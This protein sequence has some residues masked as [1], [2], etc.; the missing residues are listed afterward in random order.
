MRILHLGKYYYPIPGG[1]ESFLK[2][3][4]EGLTEIGDS[5]TVLCSS[6]ALAGSTETIDGVSV[7]RSPSFG[8]LFS[9][10]LTPKLLFTLHRLAR[11]HDIVHVHTPN[12]LVEAFV[13]TLPSRVPVVVSHHSDVIRQRLLLP[14]YAP[15]L[16]R[17]LR[18]A[19][20]IAVATQSHV[21]HSAY[22]PEFAQ[23]C[24]VIPYGFDPGEL[25]RSAPIEREAA[26]LKGEYGDRFILFV[27]RLVGYK[28]VSFL[29][30]AMKQ[31]QAK[32]V[33]VGDGP[34]DS[35]LKEQARQLGIADKVLFVGNLAGR[36]RL[37]AHYHASELLV[38]PSVSKNEAF[39]LVQLEAMAFSKPSVVS[40]LDSGIVEVNVDGETGLHVPPRD[41]SALATAIRSLLEDDARRARMGAAARRRF[42][43]TFTRR[44]MVGSY[45]ELY[46]KLLRESTDRA[47]RS[48]RHV[49]RA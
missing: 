28:G 26:R 32:L 40:K 20:R 23:K 31:I 6:S 7:I 43:E 22:L 1:I 4:T 25:E 30:E 29:L 2:S 16:R 9:Q 17:F 21:R 27:G 10:P 38:L 37:L 18:R 8:T 19:N 15:V 41:A 35:E 24:E 45:R 39:G 12:P 44:R 48:A 46:L 33:I 42:E 36:D 5:N 11:T 34:L 14:I 47:Q 3:L 13:L 49:S